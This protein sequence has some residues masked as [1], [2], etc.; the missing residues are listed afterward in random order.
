MQPPFP[1]YITPERALIFRITHR[2]N[3]RHFLTNG[4]HCRSS[5]ALDP[6]YVQIGNPEIIDR[7][8]VVAVPV[9]PNGVLA[10]YVPFYFTPCTPMLHNIV[11]GYNGMKMTPRSEIIV[12]VTSLDRLEATGTD[13]VIADR[14]AALS[15]TNFAS[16]RH[17]LSNLPWKDWQNRDYRKDPDRPDKFERYQ[18]EALVHQRLPT[19][20]L[21]GIVAYDQSTK[22]RLQEEAAKAEIDV[23]ISI[24]AGW[25]P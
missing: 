20:A 22:E 18:A 12:L 1:S 24:K 13:Y 23:P 6:D 10:D 11:T 5:G 21:V 4:A 25:Y 3:V 14:H 17:L 19:E 15:H 9:P 7:R 16:G 2:D 8:K